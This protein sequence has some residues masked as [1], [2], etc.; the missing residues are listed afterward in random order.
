[1]VGY[2]NGVAQALTF[3]NEKRDIDGYPKMFCSRRISLT[4]E[5]AAEAIRTAGQIYGDGG[6]PAMLA[7]YGFIEM[8]PCR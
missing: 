5:L 4:G 7:L 6:H 8:F 2:L 3:A 1:M